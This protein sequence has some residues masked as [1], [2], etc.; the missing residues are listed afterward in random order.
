MWD[1]IQRI[2]ICRLQEKSGF[3]VFSSKLYGGGNV[4]FAESSTV[5]LG[6]ESD[7]PKK[8]MGPIYYNT[9]KAMDCK[10]EGEF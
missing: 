5:F 3:D 2:I 1:S 7:D 6:V 9:M 8:W 4:L 10:A